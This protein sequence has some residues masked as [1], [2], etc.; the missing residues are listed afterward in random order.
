MWAID[1]IVRRLETRLRRGLGVRGWGLVRVQ[2]RRVI[3][4][5]ER[6]HVELPVGL[7]LGAVDPP[8]RQL[9]ERIARQVGDHRSEE[10]VQRL[11]GHVGEVDEDEAL[12][13]LAVHP[14]QSV[15]RLVEIE[16]L[17]LLL[18]ECQLTVQVV[19]PGVVLAGELA[20]EAAGLLAGLVVPHQFVAPVAADV[21]VRLHLAASGAHHDDRRVGSRQFLGEVTALAGKLLGATDVEPRPLEDRLAFQLV[22]LRAD[23]VLVGDRRGTQFGVVLRPTALGGLGESGHGCSSHSAAGARPAGCRVRSHMHARRLLRSVLP[24]V[25]AEIEN[26]K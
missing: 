23:R 10:V 26:N 2:Y 12:P 13:H 18:H 22:D 25:Y 6:I 11:L 24:T 17:V 3:E 21:V 7:D 16:E 9:L 5:L 1:L 15:T 4:L 20:A 8:R 14:H 19:A